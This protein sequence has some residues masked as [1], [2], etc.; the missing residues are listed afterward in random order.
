MADRRHPVDMQHPVGKQHPMNREGSIDYLTIEEVILLHSRLIQRAGG[1]DGVRDMGL[2]ASALAR[3]R[4]TF[5]GDDLYPDL[6]SKAAALMHSLLHNHPF[7]DG[8]KRTA[9]A[10]MGIF[11]ELNGYELTTCNEAVL[12]FTRR[13]VKGAIDLEDM[14]AWLRGGHG[15]PPVRH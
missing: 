7:I 3:P 13:V 10:A 6:W 14:V 5:G 15:V 4:A 9:V 2:L 11:L 1:A 12:D 8:N